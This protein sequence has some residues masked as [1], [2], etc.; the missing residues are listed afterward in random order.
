MSRKGENSALESHGICPRD[1]I[2]RYYSQALSW[3]EFIVA[4][5]GVMDSEKKGVC[6][7]YTWTAM[8][9]LSYRRCAL[10]TVVWRG[11][12]LLD[13]AVEQRGRL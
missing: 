7:S 11:R 1:P 10:R 2:S 5:L 6:F 3:M 4:V 13:Y 8:W 12:Y 9:M